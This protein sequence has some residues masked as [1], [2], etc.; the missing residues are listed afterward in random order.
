M[1]RGCRMFKFLFLRSNSVK[2]IRHEEKIMY[3]KL[4]G[5]ICICKLIEYEKY[6]VTQV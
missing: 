1:S 2:N 4:E 6:S 3:Y 5:K